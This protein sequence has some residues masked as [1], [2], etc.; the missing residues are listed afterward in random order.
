MDK[1]DLCEK[2]AVG[3]LG[4]TDYY[5]KDHEAEVVKAHAE[6]VTL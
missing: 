1:C 5:C 6:T 4:G 3:V 2:A